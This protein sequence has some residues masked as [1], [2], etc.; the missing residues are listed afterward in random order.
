MLNPGRMDF[1]FDVTPK[2]VAIKKPGYKASGLFGVTLNLHITHENLK[3]ELILNKLF[4]FP[5]M[6][7]CR[8]FDF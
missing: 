3:H 5:H 4:T 1:Y 6:V 8:Y 7:L 2:T